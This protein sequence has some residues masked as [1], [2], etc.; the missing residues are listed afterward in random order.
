[1]VGSSRARIVFRSS[2]HEG[3]LPPI[4]LRRKVTGR[5]PHVS[6]STI[7]HCRRGRH[8]ILP[9]GAWPA[10]SRFQ[11]WFSGHRGL[12]IERCLPMNQPLA[13]RETGVVRVDGGDLKPSTM[14]SPQDKMKGLIPLEIDRV[15]DLF[16]HFCNSG[17]LGHYRDPLLRLETLYDCET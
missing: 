4:F 16:R 1:M 2:Q 5:R 10:A 7:V 9:M 13:R 6:F 11:S 15:G 14:L 12:D 8:R 3:L 17:T